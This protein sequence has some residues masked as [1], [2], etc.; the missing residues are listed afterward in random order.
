MVG[1][2]PEEVC[3]GAVRLKPGRLVEPDPLQRVEGAERGMPVGAAH[4]RA[5]QFLLLSWQGRGVRRHPAFTHS[6]PEGI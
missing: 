1:N 2:I 6:P 3:V 5:G 4:T